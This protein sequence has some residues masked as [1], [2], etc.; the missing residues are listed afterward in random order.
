MFRYLFCFFVY[1]LCHFA[2]NHKYYNCNNWR[3]LYSIILF[4]RARFGRF[5]LHDTLCVRFK[6]TFYSERNFFV[7]PTDSQKRENVYRLVMTCRYATRQMYTLV[8]TRGE[9]Q[10]RLKHVNT[11]C[12]RKLYPLQKC[13]LRR[14]E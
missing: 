10:M 13:C 3:K 8:V 12:T 14:T 7:P 6:Q 11:Q 5:A 4:S 2:R 1:L 9:R